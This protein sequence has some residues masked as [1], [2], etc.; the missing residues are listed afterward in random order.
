MRKPTSKEAL[1]V[2]VWS[3]LAT[4]IQ[5]ILLF[6]LTPVFVPLG[7][8]A[9]IITILVLFLGHIISLFSLILTQKL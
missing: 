8:A 2:L 3:V 5:I 7:E 6:I 1:G 9:V 4:A